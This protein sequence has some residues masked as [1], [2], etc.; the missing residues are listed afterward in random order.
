MKTRIEKDS[1]GEVAVPENAYWGAQTQRAY[2]NF[3]IGD[4]HFPPT[5]IRALAIIK[6]AAATVNAKL[7]GITS[8]IADLICRAADEVADGKLADQFPPTN[9]ANR[10]RHTDTHEHQ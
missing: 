2:I 6:H 3:D 4:E 5:F 9:L 10:Q 8:D 1:L 7:G